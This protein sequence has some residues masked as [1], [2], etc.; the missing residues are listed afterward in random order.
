MTFPGVKM[1]HHFIQRGVEILLVAASYLA[2]KLKMSS[3]LTGS[4]LVYT[5][6]LFTIDFSSPV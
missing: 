3:G 5:C 1:E 4:W 2:L 6:G